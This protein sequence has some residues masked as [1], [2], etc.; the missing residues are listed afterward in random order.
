MT[1]ENET[2]DRIRLISVGSRISYG[3]WRG[4][5]R[6]VG[7]VLTTEGDWLGIEWDDAS[8]GK[9]D[10]SHKGRRYFNCLKQA[11]AGSF[12]RPSSSKLSFGSSFLQS[13]RY[14]YI[15]IETEHENQDKISSNQ[16]FSRKNLAEIEIE[17]PNMEGV[18][19]RNAELHRLREVGLGG[20]KM[21]RS[22]D[23]NLQ[24]DLDADRPE[25]FAEVARA[26]D[27]EQNESEGDIA[28]TCPNIRWLDLSRSLLPSWLE[29]SKITK[30]LQCLETIL[31]HFNRFDGVLEAEGELDK[32][33]FANLKDLRADG[34]FISW[35]ELCQI[36]LHMPSLTS[37]QVGANRM[38]TFATDS[39]KDIQ[40]FPQLTQ[41]NLANNGIADWPALLFALEICPKIERI[42]LSDN[43]ITSI[44][45]PSH[46]RN[47]AKPRKIQHISLNSNALQS[48]TDLE[49]LDAWCMGLQSLSLTAENCPFL[50]SLDL[51]DVRPLIIGRLPHL[52]FLNH[53][54]ISQTER[55]DAELYYLSRASKEVFDLNTAQQNQLHPRLQGLR[56]MHDRQEEG[57]DESNDRQQDQK[58]TLRNKLLPIKIYVSTS[59]PTSKSP[60]ITSPQTTD[61]AQTKSI[62]VNLLATTPVRLLQPK[63][64]R[65]LGLKGGARS[66]DSIWALLSPNINPELST[67]IQIRNEMR[68]AESLNGTNGTKQQLDGPDEERIIYPLDNLDWDLSA[69]NIT[70]DDQLII[71]LNEEQ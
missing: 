25:S 59:I 54:T 38:N 57:K 11:N 30:E 51:R 52:Q 23:M 15:N 33:S 7:P 42:I 63:I 28:K 4:T 20:W 22:T 68:P 1:S 21:E 18:R 29:L 35:Q 34:M 12:I 45:S 5:V 47:G 61:S 64:A 31:L 27:K 49:N 66:I 9:H 60:F 41:I 10:G 13:I 43:A 32:Q 65:S 40:P 17:A 55:R 8:R 58:S 2:E 53:A 26:F 69:Y 36:A 56:K 37:L 62:E 50:A 48:W 19:R 46:S 16:Q 67:A 14:K 6:Y 71:V 24:A 44:P 70:R 39:A 3:P